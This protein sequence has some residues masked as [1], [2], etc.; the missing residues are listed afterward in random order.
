MG[1]PDED[2]G[3]GWNAERVLDPGNGFC[4][5]KGTPHFVSTECHSR[6]FGE[7]EDE[8]WRVLKCCKCGHRQD[9]V[10][11]VQ[12]PFREGPLG[13]PLIPRGEALR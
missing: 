11:V 6:Q 2:W 4:V 12:H 1:I 10:K 13:A 8:F 5:R 3:P 7:Y 9:W